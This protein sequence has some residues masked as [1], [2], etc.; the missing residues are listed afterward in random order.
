M[1]KVYDYYL[2]ME[3]LSNDADYQDWLCQQSE[4]TEKELN[5]MAQEQE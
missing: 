3:E 1:S 4:M 2:E 5:E